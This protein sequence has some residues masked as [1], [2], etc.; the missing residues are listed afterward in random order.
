MNKRNKIKEIENHK[1]KILVT[2]ALPYANGAPHIGHMVEYIQTDIF[3][4]FLKQIGKDVIYVCASDTHGAPISIKAEKLGIKPEELVDI[5]SKK[6]KQDFDDFNIGLDSFYTTNSKENEYYSDL[7][8]NIMK[9]KGLIYKKKIKQMYCPKCKRFLPDRYVKGEC[10]K[11]HAKDQYGDQC[12]VCG[13]KYEPTDLINPYCAICGTKPIL[14]ETEHYFFRLTDFK[15]KLKKYIEERDFQSDIKK[16]ILNWLDDLKDWCISRDAPYFGFKI[17]GEK[18]K[19][20][21]VWLDAP[22]GYISSTLKYCKKNNINIDE[23]WKNDKTKIIHFIGKDIIYFHFLFWPAMLMSVGFNLPFDMVVHGFLKLSGKKLSKSRGTMIEARRYLDVLDPSYLRY[24]YASNLSSKV[25]DINLDWNDFKEK[26]NNE[27]V[28]KI[29]NFVYRVLNFVNS[30]LDSEIK[31][32]NEDDRMKKIMDDI[33][34]RIGKIKDAYLGYEFRTVVKL[35]NEIADIGNRYFQDNEPWKFIKDKKKEKMYNVVSFSANIVKILSILLFP[36]IPNIAKKIQEQ[37]NYNN[38][39]WN[40]LDFDLKNHRINKSGILLRKIDDETIKKIFEKDLFSKLDLR[41]ARIINV[42][43]HPN[44]DKLYLLNIDLGNEKRRIVAGLKKWYKP[45]EL[46][47]KK[48]VVICNLKPSVI[49]GIK[50]EAMLL[51]ADNGKDVGLLSVDDKEGSA[52]FV[53]E[54]NITDVDKTR[55]IDIKEFLSLGLYVKD[56]FAY[57]NNKRLR[58]KD[59]EIRCDI[60]E[61]KVR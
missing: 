44:A 41:V 37:I 25:E 26:S 55:L 33:N 15:D 11:C 13:A 30:H 61:G 8:F 20:F 57:Y 9:E 46:V 58:T 45:E 29:M 56:Y 16:F 6:Q 43:N 32:F 42:E 1:G 59:K 24:Y 23:Y 21:Y 35:I 17:P 40:E 49:R 5:Y 22:I 4:R 27:L 47:N 52:V 3:V 10:P 28:A 18:D 50:S 38:F 34:E 31:E 36:I 14:K 39:N 2:S 54:K 12:E 60:K 7:F 48:I 53:D 51:A 19:Y